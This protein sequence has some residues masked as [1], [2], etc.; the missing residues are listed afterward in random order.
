MDINLT[1]KANDIRKALN[2]KATMVGELMLYIIAT[3]GSPGAIMELA[4]GGRNV[5]IET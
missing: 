2:V 5:Y 3:S 4:R 1:P